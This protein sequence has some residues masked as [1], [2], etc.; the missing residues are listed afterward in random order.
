MLPLHFAIISGNLECVKYI[1]MNGGRINGK[2]KFKRT[3][4]ATAS[5]NGLSKI[6][7]YLLYL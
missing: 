3:P 7:S 6:A 1:L 5:M 4:L 2:D